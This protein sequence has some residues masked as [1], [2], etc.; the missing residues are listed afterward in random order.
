MRCRRIFS[1]EVFGFEFGP[2]IC[3]YGVLIVLDVGLNE[4][5]FVCTGNDGG[6]L[7]V[8]ERKLYGGGGQWH[9]ELLADGLYAA[10]FF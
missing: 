1:Q 8:C 5:G 4:F 7:G 9:V 2:E 3:W 6:D 10:G